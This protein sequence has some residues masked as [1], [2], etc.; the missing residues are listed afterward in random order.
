[1]PAP[2]EFLGRALLFLAL[3]Q[4]IVRRAGARPRRRAIGVEFLLGDCDDAAI[5][6]HPDHVEALGGALEHPVLTFELGGDTFDRAPHAERLVAANA[7]ER[8]LLLDHARA[9]GGG[10]EIELRP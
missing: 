9:R 1:M 6:A 5:L 2:H 4:V 7:V 3:A 10:A 8:L